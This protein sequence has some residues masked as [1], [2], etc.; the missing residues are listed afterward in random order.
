VFVKTI[1][2]SR[3]ATKRYLGEESDDETYVDGKELLES[4]ERGESKSVGARG[5]KTTARCA[6]AERRVVPHGS[7]L[8]ARAQPKGVTGQ[9]PVRHAECVGRRA[10]K[11]SGVRNCFDNFKRVTRVERSP[12]E[13]SVSPRGDILGGQPHVAKTQARSLANLA[14]GKG[15]AVCEPRTKRSEKA[16]GRRPST[17]CRRLRIWMSPP[18]CNDIIRAHVTHALNASLALGHKSRQSDTVNSQWS[19]ASV[20]NF[21][22]FSSQQGPVFGRILAKATV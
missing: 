6:G 22:G 8:G 5:L 15:A 14:D 4:V 13:L 21:V 11:A 9:D 12:Q 17:G 16:V 1:I 20:P 18:R 10:L 7:A 3:K 19:F 2:P